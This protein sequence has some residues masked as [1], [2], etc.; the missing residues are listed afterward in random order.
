MQK[1]RFKKIFSLLFV[2]VLAVLIVRGVS[3][4]TYAR[5]PLPEA[6]AAVQSDD[7]VAVTDSPWLIFTPAQVAPKRDSFF[8]PAG[9][10]IRA[11]I[12][13]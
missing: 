4:A 13:P 1:N 8:T 10:L 2:G 12:Q 6:I 9:A 11:D 5:S 7:L 3:W